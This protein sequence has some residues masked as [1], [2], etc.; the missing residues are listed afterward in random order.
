MALLIR[1]DDFMNSIHD[2]DEDVQA[3]LFFMYYKFYE[4]YPEDDIES[5]WEDMFHDTMG[6]G[7][8]FYL[9]N[10]EDYEEVFK[11][12]PDMMDFVEPDIVLTHMKDFPE[13]SFRRY[14]LQEFNMEVLNLLANQ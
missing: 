5:F 1:Y 11:I 2:F 8:F 10:Q 3:Y 13:D 7:V 9:Q 6:P 4:D 14:C 12:V